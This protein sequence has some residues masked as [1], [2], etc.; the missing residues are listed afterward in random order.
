MQVARNKTVDLIRRQQKL[1]KISEELGSLLQ[2]E[3][4]YTIGQFFLDTK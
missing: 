1:S 2:S 4:E 3:A